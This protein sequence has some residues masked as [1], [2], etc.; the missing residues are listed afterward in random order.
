MPVAIA[1]DNV[2]GATGGLPFGPYHPFV[3]GDRMTAPAIL[4][5][6]LASFFA[7]GIL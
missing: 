7:G 1:G 3:G 6:R 2:P 4:M 5:S